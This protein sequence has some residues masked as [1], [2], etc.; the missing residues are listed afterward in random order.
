MA[1][2]NAEDFSSHL[3]EMVEDD[4]FRATEEGSWV[5]H[6]GVNPATGLVGDKHFWMVEREGLVFGSGWRHDAPG[7]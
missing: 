7:G 4:S 1:H 5:N 3:Q 2:Y 6:E